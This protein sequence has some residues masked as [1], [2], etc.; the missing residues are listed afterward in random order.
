MCVSRSRT[1][2]FDVITF[3]VEPGLVCCPRDIVE[4]KAVMTS[5]V[6]IR[7]NSG[8]IRESAS[9]HDASETGGLNRPAGVELFY[10][11]F[12][13][14]PVAIRDEITGTSRNLIPGSEGTLLLC[15]PESYNALYT[16]SNYPSRSCMPSPCF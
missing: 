3:S 2:V 15:N 1:F 11:A 6:K 5:T 16:L 7:K 14:M 12:A 9:V 13:L 4:E 8:E 10:Q